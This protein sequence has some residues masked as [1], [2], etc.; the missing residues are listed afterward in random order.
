[1]I[2]IWLLIAGMFGLVAIEQQSIRP[3][4]FVVVVWLLVT[5]VTKRLEATATSDGRSLWW[6]WLLGAVLFGPL[7]LA[8]LAS[9]RGAP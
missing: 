5:P 1:M 7:I 3:I 4:A 8:I 9:W 2:I 6:L